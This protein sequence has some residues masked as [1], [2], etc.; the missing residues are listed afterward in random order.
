MNRPGTVDGRNWSWRLERPLAAA[1]A[2][3]LAQLTAEAGRGIVGA[4]HRR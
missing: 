3:W 2:E 1:Q 4:V